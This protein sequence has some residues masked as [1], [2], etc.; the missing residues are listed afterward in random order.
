M[1]SYASTIK[2]AGGLKPVSDEFSQ[3]MK[4]PKR[5]LLGPGPSNLSER[6]IKAISNPLLGHMHLET[7]KVSNNAIN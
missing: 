3:P 5:L 2:K 4:V 1:Q 7:F 6:V